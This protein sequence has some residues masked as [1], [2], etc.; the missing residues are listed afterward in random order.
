MAETLD[1]TLLFDAA[2]DT[3][4][5]T[6]QDADGT[7]HTITL[8]GHNL[9]ALFQASSEA[10]CQ[11]HRLPGQRPDDPTLVHGIRSYKLERPFPSNALLIRLDLASG[12]RLTCYIGHTRE[13]E[14][15]QKVAGMWRGEIDLPEPQAGPSR[16]Q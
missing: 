11:R 3:A 13:P 1:P 5:L 15:A 16:T 8:P 4:T 10:V 7:D 12:A 14:F 2:T 6:L 9:V